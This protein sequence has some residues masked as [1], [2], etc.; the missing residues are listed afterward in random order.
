MALFSSIADSHFLAKLKIAKDENLA[1]IILFLINRNNY[2]LTF[3]V[4][5]P[6]DGAI[7]PCAS[8]ISI[9]LAERL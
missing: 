2:R 3:R 8:S 9:I 4:L 7:N 5:P 1:I 6:Y